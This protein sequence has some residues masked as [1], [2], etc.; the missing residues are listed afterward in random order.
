[1]QLFFIDSFTL[2]YF[3]NNTNKKDFKLQIKEFFYLKKNC[4]LNL[5]NLAFSRKNLN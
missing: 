4:I 5:L 1:M 2:K 3:Q